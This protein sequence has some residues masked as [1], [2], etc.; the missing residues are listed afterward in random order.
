MYNL[1][2][3]DDEKSILDGLYYN[4]DWNELDIK[5]VFRAADVS[6]AL[7]ILESRHIDIVITDIRMPGTDGLTLC[8]TI[9]KLNVYTKIIILS[10]YKDFDYAQRAIDKKVFRYVLK[11]LEYEVLEKI[12]SDAL[13]EIKQD[14]Q[15]SFIVEEAKKKIDQIR[16]FIQE[17]YLNLWL[18]KGIEAPWKT[19]GTLAES[20]LDIFPDDY[21]FFVTIKVD[22]WISQPV[23]SSIVNIA[24]KDLSFQLLCE[25]CRMITYHSMTD[26][27]N[28]LFLSQDQE[29]L[30]LLFKQ[31][32]D[33]LEFFQLSIT[34]SLGCTVSIFWDFPVEL[35]RTGEAYQSISERIRRRIG[36]L[37][38]GIL[39]PEAVDNK[40]SNE[41][42]TLLKQP[43][44]L[45]L[46]S[47]FQREKLTARI[48]EIFEE[49]RQSD[50][51]TQDNILQTYHA[52]TGTLIS[53]SL[54]RNIRINQW[55]RNFK[56]FFENSKTLISLDLFEELCYRAVNQYMDFIE[57][58][59]L[60]QN[61]KVVEKIKYMIKEQI[62]SDISVSS[63][64]RTFNYNSNYLSRI[65]KLE[66]GTALQDYIIQVRIE[67][68]KA[69]LAQGERVSDVS[70][71]V[72]YE[73][74]PHFS[75]IFKKV[76]GVSPKQYQVNFMC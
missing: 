4:I 76:V 70:A 42:K 52:V 28:L 20:G 55:G 37:S 2:L 74:F 1:L 50:Y 24:L 14:L 53:D 62:S 48:A 39:G 16:P 8:D 65:F 35:A 13:L 51:Q 23:N 59:Q 17:R 73:N 19:S 25:N 40:Q 31:T 60:T 26:S 69:L 18:E 66:T 41:L 64:S 12:V 75:R 36:F 67:K 10:G 47:S 27:Y 57:N 68:A 5:D 38:G 63:L 32:I 33:R 44:L 3:V 22:E 56:E 6:S 7:K 71:K 61:R 15:K 72:G 9:L 54:Q 43:S 49:L 30:D 46:L 45:T 21:G 11:P 58:M 29:W 34:E